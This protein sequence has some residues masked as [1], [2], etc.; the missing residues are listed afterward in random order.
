MSWVIENLSNVLI[1]A[2][3]GAL[4]VDMV[5]F[6]FGTFILVFLGGSLLL[7]GLAMLMGFL[8]ST[9]DAALWSNAVLTIAL[10]ILLWKPLRRFQNK[11]GSKEIESDFAEETFVLQ[12]DVDIQ[13][14]AVH[15]YSGISWKLKSETP[16]SKGTL[17]E[18]TKVEVGVLWVQEKWS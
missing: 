6:G 17:V 12:Q 18:V 9:L 11:N 13:G 8:P 16:I 1:A 4:I 15:K 14:L 2:G 10:G 7:S 3:I 5:F